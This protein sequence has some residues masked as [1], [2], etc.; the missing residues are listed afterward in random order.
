[1]DKY[2]NF[3]KTIALAFSMVLLVSCEDYL[4]KSPDKESMDDIDVFSKYENFRKY[5]DQAYL[6][7]YTPFSG[8]YSTEGGN[9]TLSSTLCDETFPALINGSFVREYFNGDYQSIMNAPAAPVYAGHTWNPA[10]DFVLKWPLAWQG[11]AICN[12]AESKMDWLLDAT[13]EQKSEMLGQI[14]FLRAYFHFEILIRWGGFEYMRENMRLS[15]LRP[16]K[17]TSLDEMVTGIIED[18]ESAMK[19]LPDQ[20]RDAELGRPPKASAMALKS[21]VL[22]YAASPLYNETNDSKKWQDAADAAWDLISY[23][24]SSGLYQLIN[25]SDANSIDVGYDESTKTFGS[26][27]YVFEPEELRSYRSIHLYN[28]INSEVI[29]NVYRDNNL[30][31]VEGSRQLGQH[32]AYMAGK[33]K[34]WYGWTNISKGHGATENMVKKFEMKN[35]YS[36]D[37]NAAG[38]DPQN[39]YVNRDPRFY[40]NILFDKVACRGNTRSVFRTAN[41][42]SY[43]AGVTQYAKNPTLRIA[44]PS[45]TNTSDIMNVTGYCVRKYWLKDWYNG[46]PNQYIQNVIF[47]LAEAYLN[48]AEAAFEGYGGAVGATP[49]ASLTAIDAINVIRNRVGMPNVRSEY[50]TSDESVRECIH[51]ERAVELC[52]ENHRYDDLRRWKE[53]HLLEN[54]EI[55]VMNINYVGVSDEYPTGFRFKEDNLKI[56]DVKHELVFEKKHYWWPLRTSETEIFEGFEQTE[57][58]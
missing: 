53:F 48:Y 8:V 33:G 10:A 7:L 30:K 13:Q 2:I 22:L 5:L 19:L 21:R 55:K 26:D 52:F 32:V 56:S 24:E 39:P 38:Y 4:D 16:L 36:I 28:P 41:T 9:H 18:C 12:E 51:N 23:A 17:R 46:Q 49:G 11:I 29:F 57:G 15:E 27:L 1:M 20:W 35:G 58:W 43:T 50:L 6:K 54:R 3:I 31:W 42:M 34:D 40:A 25:C 37:D 45:A 47:R 44:Q 14:N